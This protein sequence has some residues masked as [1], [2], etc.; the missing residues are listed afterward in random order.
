MKKS[1]LSYLSLFFCCT[2]FA[3]AQDINNLRCQEISIISDTLIFDTISIIPGTIF[4]K[5]PDGTVLNDSLYII[6]PVSAK[7]FFDDTTAMS[8]T[9]LTICYRNFPYDFK[10]KHYNK[11]RDMIE[12]DG[13]GSYNPFKFG[14]SD[15][16]ADIF[17]FDG[18]NKSGSISRGINFGNNQDIV[19]NSN[20]NLQL[21]GK[22]GKEIDILAAITDNNMP[23]QPYGNTQYI[24]E[25]DKV[26]IQL[27]A[28]RSKLI[29]GDFELTKPKGYFMNYYKKVQGGDFQTSFNPDKD[30]KSLMDIHVAGAL[31]KG[32]FARNTV[33]AIEGNQGPY[34]LRGNENELYIIVLAGTERV[35]IDGLLLTRGQEYDYII[36][37]NTAE[38]TFTPNVLITKDKRITVEF[39]YSDKNYARSLFYVGSGFETK[40]GSNNNNGLKLGFNFF[41]EQ[42]LKNQSLQQDLTADQKY[43]LSLIG[44]SINNA[45]IKRID[46][47]GYSTDEVLYMIK[48][49]IVNNRY[50][51][52]VFVYPDVPDSAAVY[53]VGFTLVG[54]NKGNYIQEINAVNGRVYRWIAP[55]D[56]IPQGSYEPVSLLITPAKSQ[57]LS[58][59]GEYSIA[60]KTKLMIELA[61]SNRDINT[62]SKID[63][64]NNKGYGIKTQ[65]Q[66][67]IK[68]SNSA[69]TNNLWL[70]ITGIDYEWK[71]KNFSP[72]EP[73][74]EVEFTR[75]WNRSSVKTDA[76]E[77]ISTIIIGIENKK[78]GIAN[79]SFQLFQNGS[80]YSA[81]KN[82]LY[83][84]FHKKGYQ[85]ILDGSLLNTKEIIFNTRFLRSKAILSKSFG[86]ITIGI[87]NEQ[88]NNIYT[89]KS[90]D[91]IMPESYS[92]NEFEI[93]ITNPDSVRN[94]YSGY[95]KQRIDKIASLSNMKTTS[96]AEEVG[97]SMKLLKN[98]NNRFN[99][100]ASFRNLQISDTSFTI[101]K[102]ENNVVGRL[103]YF[104]KQLKGFIT[105]N[106]YYEI[107]S[108]QELKKEFS[109]LKVPDGEGIYTWVD[110]NEDGIQQLNEFEISKFKDQANYIRISLPTNAYIR[111]F[112]NQ[113]SNGLHI[114]P[115]AIIMNRSGFMK[116]VTRF[117]NQT[118]YQIEHKTTSDDPFMRFNPFISENKFSDSLLVSMSSSF[119]NTTFFNRNDPKFGVDVGFQNN[120]TKILMVNGFDTRIIKYFSTNVRWRFISSSTFFVDYKS[121]KNVS[122]SEFFSSRDYSIK[123]YEIQPKISWQPNKS[124]LID[125]MYNYKI[126][127]NELNGNAEPV[128]N[129]RSINQKLGLVLNYKMVNKGNLQFGLDLLHINYN[130]SENTTLAYEM[131]EGFRIGNNVSWI[132][133]YQQNLSKYLQLNLIYNG[134][135]SSEVK[136]IHLGNVQIRAYF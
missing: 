35:F 38:I 75:N 33:Q 26:F 47:V 12:P 110:Y 34:K 49:T 59:A 57:M 82:N 112:F 92:F 88:E 68:L 70:M 76:D 87:K 79:Y 44:D 100:N 107:G 130:A 125:F 118:A 101:Q 43:L 120:N 32:K 25:F 128:H 17:E 105:F 20:L 121:G 74:R 114:R 119:R 53:R 115:A 24:Q 95:Y 64:D 10:K 27:S 133:S 30:N 61:L 85:F 104:T 13:S 109:Y 60:D 58:I 72:I 86:K 45:Y 37:Y 48:D 122:T 77:H 14:I 116:A 16:D 80:R 71:S 67:K 124:L 3:Q 102:P 84:K 18:L 29:A 136:T 108:G 103:E 69:D 39:E 55:V 41:S 46:S 135:K 42:D 62:F 6:D 52:S 123:L 65:L 22:L 5:K 134:R 96:V 89:E 54:A 99:L 1:C 51:D 8:D 73:Y 36:D 19:V 90:N 81:Y 93:F 56:S 131:L 113:Y 94:R 15:R 129:E 4:I 7:L 127:T 83:T 117:S 21:S 126:K 97:F 111:T 28:K 63:N 31:S 106:I 91:S 11:S 132:L 2:I 50:Y 78:T 66:Q 98:S 23:I 9:K 40:T